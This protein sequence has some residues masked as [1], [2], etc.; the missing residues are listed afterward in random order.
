MRLRLMAAVVMLTVAAPVALAEDKKAPAKADERE[1][2]LKALID[3]FVKAR[4]EGY[5]ALRQAQTAEEKKAAEAKLPKEADY[6]PRIHLLVAGGAKDNVAAEALAFAVFGLDTKDEKVFEALNNHFVKTDKIRR[7]VQMAA[8]SGAPDGARPVL[9]TVLEKNPTKELKGL[10]CYALGAMAFEK[11]GENAAKEA[12]AYFARVEKDFAD[13]KAGRK[14]TLGEMAKGS[15]FELRNLQVGMKAPPAESKNLN[16]EKVSLADY[17]GKVVVLDIWTTWCGPCKAMIPHER[18]MVAK[19]KDKPFALI[20]LSVDEQKKEL[21]EFLD[22][23]SMPWTHWWDGAE[24]PLV[25]QWNVRFFPTIYVID[26]K[27]VIRHKNIRG[28]E[29]E[30]AV[31]KLVA[32]T[33]P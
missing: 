23:E 3:E 30:K 5:V 7:F 6:L 2:Q 29:L 24:A 20:S 25:K 8:M 10:A 19:L 16:G 13:I 11:D 33:K 22:R 18:E 21:E 17:Q 27:G 32:E 1:I 15:L 12:E 31:E 26:A 28:E 4:K 9:V 14:G